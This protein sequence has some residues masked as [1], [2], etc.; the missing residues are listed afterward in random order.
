MLFTF[1]NVSINT[2]TSQEMAT[3]AETFTFHNVSINT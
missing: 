2:Y 1:H 3:V